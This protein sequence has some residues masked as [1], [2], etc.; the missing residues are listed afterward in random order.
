M[1]I[2]QN[3]ALILIIGALALNY[4]LIREL[5]KRNAELETMVTKLLK[6]TP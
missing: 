6:V 5:I 1:E 4:A 2:M 3:I